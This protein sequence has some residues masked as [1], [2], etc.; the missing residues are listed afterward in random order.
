MTRV[1]DWLI[2]GPEPYLATCERCGLH[3]L[4]PPMRMTITTLIGFLER[5]IAQHSACKRI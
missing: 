3:V 2:V 1:G 5:S 4:M